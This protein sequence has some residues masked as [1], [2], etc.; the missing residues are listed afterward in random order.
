MVTT[1]A[2]AFTRHKIIDI[3]I[4]L[5]VLFY[6]GSMAWINPRAIRGFY[7]ITYRRRYLWVALC[8]VCKKNHS[9]EKAVVVEIIK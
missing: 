8:L 4:A 5:F 3:V 6:Y 2:H 1:I 7:R 9:S